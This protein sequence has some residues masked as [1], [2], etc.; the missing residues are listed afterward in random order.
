VTRVDGERGENEK[1]LSSEKNVDEVR[2]FLGEFRGIENLNACVCKGGEDFVFQ[3]CVRTQV[4]V[5]R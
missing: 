1:Y 3:A 5:V 4:K 2:F